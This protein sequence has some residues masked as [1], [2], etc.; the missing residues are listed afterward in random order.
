[1]TSIFL[2]QDNIRRFVDEFTNGQAKF[3]SVP[4]DQA[5]FTKLFKPAWNDSSHQAFPRFHRNGGKGVDT[6]STGLKK[7]VG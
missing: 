3:R 2:F 6:Y 5:P 1:M 4:E 7:T